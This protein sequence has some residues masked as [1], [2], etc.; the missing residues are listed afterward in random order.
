M[1]IFVSLL[2]G[3][4]IAAG[5]TSARAADFKSFKDSPSAVEPVGN[6]FAGFYGGLTAGAQFTDITITSGGDDFSGLSADGGLVGGH[7]GFNYCTGRFCFGPVAEFAF[8]NVS[9][10]FGPLGDVLVMDDYFQLVAQAGITVGRQTL[11]SIHA[12]YEWQNWRLD[13]DRIGLGEHDADVGAWVVGGSIETLISRNISAALVVDYLMLDDVND[14]D[15]LT[16]ALEKSD[17]LRI[18]LRATYHLND[19]LPELF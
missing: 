12:G 1:R 4:L 2:L 5:A 14:D 13:L 6:P 8:S 17:A 9:F 15:R 10:E 7:A 11:I 16:D 19:G 3:L 18:K